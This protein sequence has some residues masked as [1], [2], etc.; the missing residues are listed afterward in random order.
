MTPPAV[1]EEP[2]PEWRRGLL[3]M[4]L[5]V[6]LGALALVFRRRSEA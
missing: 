5:G 4:L 6:A 3:G 2:H 1:T